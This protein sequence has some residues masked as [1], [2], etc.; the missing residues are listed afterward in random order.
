MA[1]ECTSEHNL[2]GFR[3]RFSVWYR[4]HTHVRDHHRHA[5]NAHHRR[6]TA[7]AV[8][9]IPALRNWHRAARGSVTGHIPDMPDRF[10]ADRS[11]TG[12]RTPSGSPCSEGKVTD[13]RVDAAGTASNCGAM[14]F[15]ARSNGF[16]NPRSVAPYDI[17]GLLLAVTSGNRDGLRGATRHI[18][19]ITGGDRRRISVRPIPGHVMGIGVVHIARCRW[20]HI[21]HGLAGRGPVEGIPDARPKGIV[22]AMMPERVGEQRA[23]N[24]MRRGKRGTSRRSRPRECLACRKHKRNYAERRDK[25]PIPF[26]C[27]GTHQFVGY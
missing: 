5:K 6:W 20:R 19:S 23:G 7:L 15:Q 4:F 27:H 26:I 14:L 12:R 22:S 11:P 1:T 2:H 10:F 3:C 8:I 13:R 24:R 9:A 16:F 21:C 17:D 18:G 25:R